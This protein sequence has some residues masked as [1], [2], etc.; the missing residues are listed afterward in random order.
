LIKAEALAITLSYNDAQRTSCGYRIEEHFDTFLRSRPP[1]H[2]SY[3]PPLYIILGWEECREKIV[4]YPDQPVN[5][6]FNDFEKVIEA[7]PRRMKD[8]EE[9]KMLWLAGLLPENKG[10]ELE[11]TEEGLNEAQEMLEL[12]GSVFCCPGS[13][14]S[15]SLGSRSLT[16]LP[17][18]RFLRC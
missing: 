2:W 9:E 16:S 8:W 6:G 17:I 3:R 13:H 12:A 15:I 10:R 14:A 5:G 7:I 1:S 18:S 4:A 11:N